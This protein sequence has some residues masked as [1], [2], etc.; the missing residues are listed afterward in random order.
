[1]VA[2]SLTVD[3][4]SARLDAWRS[5]LESAS[6]RADI[7]DGMSYVFRPASVFAQRVRELAA[8]EHECCAFLNFEV[9]EQDDELLL[10]VT[11]HST[12]QAALRFIFS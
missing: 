9:V 2:C 8:A 5:L 7:P 12:G 1:L 11:T 4:Q 10:N 6:T 3:D